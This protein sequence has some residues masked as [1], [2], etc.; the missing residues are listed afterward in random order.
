M[1][2]RKNAKQEVPSETVKIVE[3]ETLYPAEELAKA[4][5]RFGTKEEC[6]AA[7]LRFYGKKEATIN[8][9]QKLVKEFLN[10]EVK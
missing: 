6:V 1:A 7:A 2:E 3:H 5:K 8:E 9:T 10:K 4:H